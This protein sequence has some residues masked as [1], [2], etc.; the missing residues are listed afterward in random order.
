[1]KVRLITF[2]PG[3]ILVFKDADKEFLFKHIQVFVLVKT[4]F[5]KKKFSQELLVRKFLYPKQIV[6]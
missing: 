1:M 5:R 6:A 4:N 3:I 2:E